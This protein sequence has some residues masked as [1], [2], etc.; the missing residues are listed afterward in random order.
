MAISSIIIGFL[1][2]YETVGI[3]AVVFLIALRFIQGISYGGEL[4][5]ATI[6]IIERYK[7]HQPL[8]ILFLS[9]MVVAGVFFAKLTYFILGQFF[10][11]QDMMDYGWRIAYIFGGIMIFHS[12]FA[13]KE[14]AESYEFKLIQKGKVYKNTIREMFLNYKM[15]LLIGVLSLASAQMFWGVFMIYLPNFM[16]LKYNNASITSNIYYLVMLGMFLGDIIGAICADKVNVRSVYSVGTILTC[17]L[18]IPLYISMSNDHRTTMSVFYFLLFL[19]SFVYGF[20]AVLCLL[21]L[22]KRYPVKYRYTLVATT[23]A[24]AAF[25][26]IGLPPFLFSYFT[27][28]VS[29]FYPMLVFGIGCI[30][31][32]IAVQ[33]FYKKTE[34]FIANDK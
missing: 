2:T 12:Y 1:P 15:L 20:F 21:M 19:T 23:N 9:L 24:F 11:H 14:I 25:F 10:N 7:E 22:S 27:R 33:L 28:E 34:K 29:M 31:Q 6:V 4:S 3:L 13:R 32:L 8:L 17:L 18:L 26:F 16:E 5:G 30:V